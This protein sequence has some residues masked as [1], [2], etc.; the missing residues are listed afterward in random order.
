MILKKKVEIDLLVQIKVKAIV[1]GPLL[2]YKKMMT[3]KKIDLS[4]SEQKE[5]PRDHKE[6][7]LALVIY[8]ESA[9]YVP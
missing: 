1:V 6:P 7:S 9:Q 3:A 2:L 8:L 5:T 4:C